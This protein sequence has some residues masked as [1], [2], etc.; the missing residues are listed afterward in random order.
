VGSVSALWRWK[1]AAAV[2]VVGIAASVVASARASMSPTETIELV[3]IAAGVSAVGLFAS[4]IGAHLLRGHRLGVQVV[5]VLITTLTAMMI[6]AFAAARA[7]FISEHDLSILLVVFIAGGTVAGVA[8]MVVARRVDTATRALGDMARGFGAGGEPATAL[9]NAPTEL[10]RLADE[11]RRA[12]HQLD[13]SRR[14]QERIERS[15]RELVAWVSHDLRTPLAGIRA[16]VE[17]LQDGI[18][19]DPELVA[20]YLDT[21]GVE[22]ARLSRLVDDLFELSRTQSGALKLDLA[23]VFLSD[24]VEDGLAGGRAVA[25]AKGVHLEQ[26]VTGPTTTLIV[27]A[28]EVV[29]ALRNLVDN[30]IRHTPRGGRVVVEAFVDGGDPAYATVVVSDSGGGVAEADLGRVFDVA[31]QGDQARTGGGAGLGLAIAKGFIEAHQGELTV[32]NVGGGAHFTIR[33]PLVST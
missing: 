30:A 7:M 3:G 11:L 8:S 25:T 6:G 16:I 4:L 24:L 17:M 27:S 15:R 1:G 26:R 18:V 12:E 31:F 19:D 22:V 29:R 23:P 21:L 10:T 14:H 9:R 28:P 32:R 33:L 20:R 2:L 5:M 13:A